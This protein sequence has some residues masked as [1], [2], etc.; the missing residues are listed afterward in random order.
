M[1]QWELV[2]HFFAHSVNFTKTQ[3]FTYTCETLRYAS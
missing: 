3:E 2:L 1:D